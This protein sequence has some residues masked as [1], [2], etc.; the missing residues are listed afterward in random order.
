MH[1]WLQ[2]F[3]NLKALKII[4]KWK[5]LDRRVL[6]HL[7]SLVV[8]YDAAK[9]PLGRTQGAVEH[10]DVDLA[11]LVLVLQAATNFK[12]SAFFSKHKQ[13]KS[14]EKRRNLR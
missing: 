1:I 14:Q 4:R 11:T 8:F 3:G 6:G 2:N 13:N 10:M 9:S 12:S 5:R 7:G